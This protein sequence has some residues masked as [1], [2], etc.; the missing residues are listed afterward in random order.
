MLWKIMSRLWGKFFSS[1]F[2]DDQATIPFLGRVLGFCPQPCFSLGKKFFLKAISMMDSPDTDRRT[3]RQT[4]RHRSRIFGAYVP[5][6]AE[7]RQL[8][9]KTQSISGREIATWEYRAR[10]DSCS[11]LA[12][13]SRKV[14][15]NQRGLWPTKTKWLDRY[16]SHRP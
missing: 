3:D 11:V 7:R 12:F 16:G 6:S 14:I 15:R 2:V 8:V 4:D 13:W 1:K 5:R 10:F 9:T